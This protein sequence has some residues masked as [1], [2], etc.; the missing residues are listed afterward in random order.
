MA[1][2]DASTAPASAARTAAGLPRRTSA[3]RAIGRRGSRPGGC[4]RMIVSLLPMNQVWRHP[5]AFSG[6]TWL[7]LLPSVPDA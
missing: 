2:A 1:A 4:A 6:G 5:V 3:L 7:G